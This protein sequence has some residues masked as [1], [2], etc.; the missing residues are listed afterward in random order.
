MGGQCQNGT[1]NFLMLSLWADYEGAEQM[2]LNYSFNG[3]ATNL[4]SSFGATGP[5]TKTVEIGYSTAMSCSA[6]RANII[7]SN[8]WKIF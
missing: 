8:L 4:V 3:T 7:R 2:Q 6:R 5:A 1:T